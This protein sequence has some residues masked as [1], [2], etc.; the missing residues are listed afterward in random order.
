MSSLLRS[1]VGDVQ[2]TITSLGAAFAGVTADRL[3]DKLIQAFGGSIRP[4]A[5]LGSVGLN[6]V[7]RSA[8]TSIAYSTAA[9]LMP[10]TS[11]NVF[12]T[13]LFFACNQTLIADARTIAQVILDPILRIASN[14]LP[15]P[16]GPPNQGQNPPHGSPS[17]A[18]AM[19][20]NSC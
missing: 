12:F 18:A 19:S 13:I 11:E 2:T 8:V 10:A 1:T 3:S 9:Q 4:S 5:G 6:F 15:P 14:P 16:R 17:G 20:C 7:A